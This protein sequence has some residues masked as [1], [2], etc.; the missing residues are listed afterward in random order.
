MEEIIQVLARLA[1]LLEQYDST[2]QG[3]A[4][5]E[6]QMEGLSRMSNGMGGEFTTDTSS[7]K[8]AVSK[9]LRLVLLQR[10]AFKRAIAEITGLAPQD[11][12]DRLSDMRLAFERAGE[13]AVEVRKVQGAFEL[14]VESNG[15][16][17]EPGETRGD[18]EERLTNLR[19]TSEIAMQQL[20]KVTN[21]AI[22]RKTIA[23]DIGP[24]DSV[25]STLKNRELGQEAKLILS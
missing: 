5:L 3:V 16:G 11:L 23:T 20:R 24:N 6:M 12:R 1:A 8:T 19:R 17:E 9:A 10:D 13:Y 21:S 15:F 4:N 22:N 14:L 2:E 18:F 7:A 25:L